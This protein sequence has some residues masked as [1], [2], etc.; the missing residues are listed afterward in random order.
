MIINVVL[1]SR[2]GKGGTSPG[3]VA[4]K[5]SQRRFLKSRENE[6]Q[7]LRETAFCEPKRRK[8]PLI[9]PAKWVY[10]VATK[11]CNSRHAASRTTGKIS[12]AKERKLFYREG[13]VGRGY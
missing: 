9:L 6:L 7:H 4:R 13:E 12:E 3:G 1:E 10:S 11:N 8:Q 2:T 5:A